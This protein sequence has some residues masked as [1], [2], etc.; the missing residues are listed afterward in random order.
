[1]G[2]ENSVAILIQWKANLDVVDS[3]G[4]TPLTFA[5]IKGYTH[6]VDL[7]LK[8]G[9]DRTKTD[10]VG[11]SIEQWASICEQDGMIRLLKEPM[12]D[13]VT[14]KS[15]W[16]RSLNDTQYGQL[17]ITHL[18]SMTDTQAL[19]T[20]VQEYGRNLEERG[21]VSGCP[22]FIG[23][24]TPPQLWGALIKM[25]GYFWDRD[26]RNVGLY[27]SMCKQIIEL[28]IP[29]ENL[30]LIKLMI[31]SDPRVA[32]EIPRGAVGGNGRTCLH[33]AAY[34]TNPAVA[35]YLLGIE[36]DPTVQDERGRT[37]LHLAAAY[38]S[39]QVA[40]TIAEKVTCNVGARDGLERTPLHRCLA[41]G[42]W[43]RNVNRAG[44]NMEIARLLLSKGA[45]AAVVD[46]HGNTTLH[47]AIVLADEQV[48]ILLILNYGT[49]LSWENHKGETPLD[50]LVDRE[51]FGFWGGRYG[52]VWDR[53]YCAEKFEFY[54]SEEQKLS[55]LRALRPYIGPKA[56]IPRR[57]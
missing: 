15:P 47:Y 38:G 24:E 26:Q 17:Y 54:S 22:S 46:K 34:C 16:S 10:L 2:N 49:E 4:W 12:E 29:R 30:P 36:A 33:T 35:Q 55:A 52:E 7:L 25:D 31:E 50:S 21:T 3:N 40:K 42:D 32:K 6:I 53:P 14:L 5:V 11:L 27:T 9:A 19:E 43:K 28:A 57:V 45:S 37:P 39:L 44:E 1:M 41:Y 56:V 8:S 51:F 13:S 48:L 20:A 23:V 18:E